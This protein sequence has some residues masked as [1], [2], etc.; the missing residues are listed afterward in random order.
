MVVE[1]MYDNGHCL[2][3]CDKNMEMDHKLRDT[4][5]KN[6][7]MDQKLKVKDEKNMEMDHK[8]RNMDQN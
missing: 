5:H 4:D 3:K 8:N 1:L 2:K 7:K 6:R